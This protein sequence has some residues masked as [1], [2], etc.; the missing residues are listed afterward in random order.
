MPEQAQPL[1]DLTWSL[2]FDS[3][4]SPLIRAAP[5]LG[6]PAHY[7]HFVGNLT[8]A[9]R[10]LTIVRLFSICISKLVPAVQALLCCFPFFLYQNQFYNFVSFSSKLSSI[11]C[12]KRQLPRT[13]WAAPCSKFT[14]QNNIW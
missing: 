14:S 13:C 10:S 5:T 8:Q 7:G 11:T 9:Q 3:Y 12:I 6:F 2:G 1:A 4:I